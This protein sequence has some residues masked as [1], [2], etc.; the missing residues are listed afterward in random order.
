VW[1]DPGQTPPRIIGPQ[2]YVN[3]VDLGHQPPLLGKVPP[4]SDC[5][6]GP[7]PPNGTVTL[8]SLNGWPT[9]L[10][11]KS[12]VY[13]S[14][15]ARTN[16]GLADHGAPLPLDGARRREQCEPRPLLPHYHRR[17][18][19]VPMKRYSGCLRPGDLL[20]VMYLTSPAQEGALNG[21]RGSPAA[22]R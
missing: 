12:A 5:T 22:S 17:A 10:R 1:A 4:T 2:Q 19:F 14:L 8:S 3:S 21:R 20:F 7:P 18:H 16:A 13:I 15:L 6:I 9:R 11:A